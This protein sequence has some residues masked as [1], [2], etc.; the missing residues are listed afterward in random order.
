MTPTKLRFGPADHGRPVTAEEFVRAEFQEGAVYEAVDGKIAVSSRP[1]LQEYRLESW[2][3]QAVERYGDSH[4]NT[5]AFVSGKA[6]V[7]VPARPELMILRPDVAVY[8]E[9]PPGDELSGLDWPDISPRIVVEV[10][11]DG[12]CHREFVRNVDL[13]FQVPSIAEY[14]ILDA[15]E[16]WEELVLTTR[17]RHNGRWWILEVPHG[18]TYTTRTLPGFELLIDPRR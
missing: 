11:V 14:W 4:P 15:R 10:V 9:L 3:C 1:S 7:W 13:Y 12:D 6:Q 5:I 16:G 18:E 17:R 2:L 8:H